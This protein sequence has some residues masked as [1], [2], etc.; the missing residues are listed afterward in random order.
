MIVEV[1]REEILQAVTEMPKDKAPGV[2]GYPIELY[3]KN[4]DIVKEDMYAAVQ[5]FFSSGVMM[6]TWN[7]TAIT[8][9]PKVPSPTQV[10]DFRPIACCSTLYKIVAK[11]LTRRLKSVVNCL[12][13]D[14]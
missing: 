10:T 4:W 2:D 1:S 14:S 7:C 6:K 5:Q 11:V 3:T 12:V 8:L 9:V 13:R